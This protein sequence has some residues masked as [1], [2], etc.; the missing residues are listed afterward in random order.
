MQHTGKVKWFN[1]RKGFGFI[2]EDSGQ[3]VFVHHTGIA[4]EGFRNLKDGEAVR[5]EVE[6][7]VKGPYAVNVIR[8]GAGSIAL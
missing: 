2:S 4:M 5:F 8:S 3:D 6:T 1:T 7:G